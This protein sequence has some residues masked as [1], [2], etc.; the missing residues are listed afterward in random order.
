MRII[1]S[2]W[3]AERGTLRGVRAAPVRRVALLQRLLVPRAEPAARAPP[4]RPRR[5]LPALLRETGARL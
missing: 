4:H 3:A 2:Q 5:R 1:V